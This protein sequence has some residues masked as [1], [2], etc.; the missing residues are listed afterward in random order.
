[1]FTILY[2]DSYIFPMHVQYNYLD[3]RTIALSGVFYQ[4]FTEKR[5]IY[6]IKIFTYSLCTIYVCTWTIGLLD[7]CSIGCSLSILLHMY[8]SIGGLLLL[9]YWTIAPF[10]LYFYMF[11]TNIYQNIWHLCLL[12]CWTIR[13]LLFLI[14]FSKIF[15]YSLCTI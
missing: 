14:F 11:S 10:N 8:Q 1:M 13:L 4:Y 12:D 2:Q 9:D 7:Y 6:F 15:T 3:Y 5:L